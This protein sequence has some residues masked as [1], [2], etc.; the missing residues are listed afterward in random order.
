MM[1]GQMFKVFD[2]KSLQDHIRSEIKDNLE[3]VEQGMMEADTAV[4]R[5]FN[6]MAGIRSVLLHDTRYDVFSKSFMDEW[7][8][9]RAKMLACKED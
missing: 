6:F 7:A 1:V 8:D 2:V 4:N 3:R 5:S 9:L